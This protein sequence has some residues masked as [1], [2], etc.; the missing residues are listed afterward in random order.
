MK[1]FRFHPIAGSKVAPDKF[2][3]TDGRTKNTIKK[4]AQNGFFFFVC[5]SIY[6]DVINQDAVNTV[7]FLFFFFAIFTYGLCGSLRGGMINVLKRLTLPPSILQAFILHRHTYRYISVSMYVIDLLFPNQ[8]WF[9]IGVSVR[10]LTPSSSSWPMDYTRLTW[11]SSTLSRHYFVL[12]VYLLLSDINIPVFVCACVSNPIWFFVHKI[13]FLSAEILCRSIV[14][15]RSTSFY[16]EFY[17]SLPF[18]YIPAR[19]IYIY[20]YRKTN[21]PFSRLRLRVKVEKSP[22]VLCV[23]MYLYIHMY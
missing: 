20:I 11:A 6:M 14:Y 16:S 4:H 21:G 3:F 1:H 7:L 23:L 22:E 18:S 13:F 8:A 5:T 9:V 15:I 17:M 2:D 12:H 19:N 10:N